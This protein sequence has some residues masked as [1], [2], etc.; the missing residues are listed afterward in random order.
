MKNIFIALLFFFVIGCAP[1]EEVSFLIQPCLY[2]F[3]FYDFT[4][5]DDFHFI[6]NGRDYKVPKG[7][8]TDLASVPR[9]LWSIYS[10]NRAETIAGAVIHDYLYSCHNGFSRA[11][12]DSIFYD[13]LVYNKVSRYT[14]FKY[15]LAVRIF[16]AS[17]FDKGDEC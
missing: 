8:E 9:I 6:F 5:C 17:H 13:S 11:Q 4:L 1:K 3:K 14:A 15:W 2:P 7:F 16:A 10:P 12:I